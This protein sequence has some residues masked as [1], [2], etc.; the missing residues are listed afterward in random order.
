MKEERR[1][2]RLSRAEGRGGRGAVLDVNARITE[3]GGKNP[4]NR[5]LIDLNLHLAARKLPRRFT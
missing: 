5:R 1:K 2:K 3:D 4:R